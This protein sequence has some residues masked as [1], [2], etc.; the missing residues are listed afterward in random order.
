MHIAVSGFDPE[1]KCAIRAPVGPW[2]KTNSGAFCDWVLERFPVKLT[3]NPRHCEVRR[4]EA[5]QFLS[6][7]CFALRSA[8]GS[9]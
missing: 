9:Q 4:T 3:Q 1:S 5:I 2:L 6:L 8:A 7:D